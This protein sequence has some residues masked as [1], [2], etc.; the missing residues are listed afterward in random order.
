MT[1]EQF[2]E[3]LR[4]EPFKPFVI[5]TADGKEYPVEHPEMDGL[6][7]LGAQPLERRPEPDPHVEPVVELERDPHQLRPDEVP[8]VLALRREPAAPE[9]GQRPVERALRQAE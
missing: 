3:Y 1:V 9:S 4:A 6:V 2:T 8:A 7:Q 5:H